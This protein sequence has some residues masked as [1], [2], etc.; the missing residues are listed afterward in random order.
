MLHL[1]HKIEHGNLP[2]LIIV[3]AMKCGTTSLHYYLSRH[4]QIYM[5]LEK[6]LNFFIREKNWNRGIEWY[7]SHFTEPVKIQ[8]ESSPSYTRYPKWSGVPERM[9]SVV[10]HAKLIY[11]LR[12]PIQRIISHYIHSYAKGRE[13]RTISEAL[14]NFDN[15]SYVDCSKYYMQ[16]RQYLNYFPDSSILV[17]SLEELS[18][19][20]HVTLQKVFMHLK[21]DENIYFKKPF[22]PFHSSDDKRRK[23]NWGER[24]QKI[25]FIKV[26]EKMPPQISWHI[27]QILYWPFSQKIY[28][29]ILEQDLHNKLSDYLRD[30]INLLRAYTGQQFNDWCV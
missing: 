15:N 29:P 23:N 19:E 26:I 3:G 1:T 5:S 6:E 18:R 7:K 27:N 9:Y 13:N 30:D 12:D 11:I 14:V 28:R 8:G 16:L 4:P 2:N 25:P 20:P 10:P 17:I 22:K 24:I 21:L